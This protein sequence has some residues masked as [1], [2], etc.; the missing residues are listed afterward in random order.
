M[1]IGSDFPIRDVKVCTQLSTQERSCVCQ[2]KWNLNDV[3][4]FFMLNYPIHDTEY[5]CTNHT[6]NQYKITCTIFKEFLQ[7]YLCLFCSIL[8]S[9][10][11]LSFMPYLFANIS[12]LHVF[13]Y[14]NLDM[15]KRLIH[16]EVFARKVLS[17]KK[18][19]NFDTV[20]TND[21]ALI[22]R[23]L[24]QESVSPKLTHLVA[25]CLSLMTNISPCPHSLATPTLPCFYVWHS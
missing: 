11:H 13:A 7:I 17:D 4:I 2:A 23:K 6:L 12:W 8:F 24:W 1:A 5:S 20:K 10:S 3:N 18:F 16:P 21:I 14:C 25:E 22:S 9:R 15:A 19:H